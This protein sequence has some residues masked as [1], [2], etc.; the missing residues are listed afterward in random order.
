[1]SLGMTSQTLNCVLVKT[2]SCQV[3]NSKR[4]GTTSF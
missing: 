4:S 3:F 2:L 1:M